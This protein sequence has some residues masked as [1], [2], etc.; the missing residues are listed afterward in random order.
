MYKDILEI[1]ENLEINEKYKKIF[2]ENCLENIFSW[3][4]CKIKKSEYYK[5]YIDWLKLKKI[6][7]INVQNINN[8]RS[9]FYKKQSSNEHVLN[10]EISVLVDNFTNDDIKIILAMKTLN[11]QV[12]HNRISVFWT[13]FISLLSLVIAIIAIFTK[14]GTGN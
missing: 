13:T 14:A 3:N 4:P 6:K 11:S 2:L 5:R 12:W 9:D 10:G 1:I 7:N 8:M